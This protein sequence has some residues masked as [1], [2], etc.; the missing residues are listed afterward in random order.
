MKV[1]A[2]SRSFARQF[3]AGAL[4]QLEWIDMAC[5]QALDGVD[6]SVE[7]FPR[8]DDDYLAQIKKLCVDR[9]LTVAGVNVGVAFGAGAI[10][11][12]VDEL[13]RAID[14]GFAIGAPLVRFA[15]GAAQ[16]SPG[17]AWR[18]L[19]RGLKT[20]CEYAK[21]RNVTLAVTPTPG[22][23]VATDAEVKRAFKECDSAWLRLALPATPDWEPFA[24]DSVIMCMPPEGF[25]LAAAARYR[26]FITLEDPTGADDTEHLRRWIGNLVL[27]EAR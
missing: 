17:V 10:E 12:Q 9:C 6:L 21:R 8:L 16:G 5:G 25:D 20:I 1:C 24:G 23:L 4:T 14:A 11:P 26:G 2:S 18:E 7:H 22:T 27:L 3:S 19:I 15:C 13:K